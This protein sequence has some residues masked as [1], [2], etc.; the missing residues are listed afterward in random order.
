MAAI[1]LGPDPLGVL[2]TTWFVVQRAR[3]VR[4]DQQAIET[5][6]DQ[7]VQ[8]AQ[9]PPAWDREL[10]Y[11]DGTWRTANVIL[12]LDA[13]NFSFWG[14]PR[15]TVVYHGRTLNGYWALAAAFKRAIEDGVPLWD[16]EVLATL[17]R[18]DLARILRGIGQVPMLDERLANLREVGAML[19][20]RY[21][22]TFTEAI[23]SVDFDA[24]EL[25]L[26]LVQ[27]CSSFDDV[28]TYDGHVVRFYKR[29][30]L[31]AADLIGAFDGRAWGALK[32]ADLLTA[33]ADYKVP[34]VLRALGILVYAAD[35]ADR[36]DRQIEIPAGSPDEVE[37]RAA[38][39][40]GVELLRRA[41][42]ARG[43]AIPAYALDWYLWTLGQTAIAERPYHR[44]RTIFY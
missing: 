24:P 37:I 28:A 12:A 32:R 31:C 11:V 13:V 35:L 16:A 22:G 33:F 14:E 30:Q 43:R 42:E 19:R 3:A 23:A 7:F 39:I 2:R 44:T 15:W 25:V 29:A 17:T 5:V 1:E 9:Q 6:A 36:I 10:H 4:I 40:W 8:T 21:H 27:A 20:A 18:D 38:T 26:L 34:Q 41:L